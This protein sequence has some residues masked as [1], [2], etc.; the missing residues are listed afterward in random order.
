MFQVRNVFAAA[1]CAF[2]LAQPASA[3][4]AGAEYSVRWDPAQGGPASAA[5]ALQALQLR[6]TDSAE[7]EVLYFDVADPADLPKGFGAILRKR[8]TADAAQLTFKLRG[9]APLPDRPSLKNWT[10]PLP[11]PNKRKDEVDITFL[12]IDDARKAYSRSCSHSTR[13]RSVTAPAALHAIA[14]GCMSTMQRL[15]AGALKLEHWRMADGSSLIEA[16]Q[17]GRDRQRDADAFRDKVL[18]PLLAHGVRPIDRSKSTI[19]GSC[20]K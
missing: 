15:E 4:Q 20:G 1:L 2:V 7:F 13:D 9:T 5:D 17:I 19:G 11:Q 14:K 10:C 12:G 18:K 3:K 8:L 6:R 16:S